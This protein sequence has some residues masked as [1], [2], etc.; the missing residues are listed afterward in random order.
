MNIQAE[1]QT[2]KSPTRGPHNPALLI[3]SQADISPKTR[4][5]ISLTPAPTLKKYSLLNPIK[6][7]LIFND[8]N[9]QG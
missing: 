7:V 5:W 6:V 2:G 4:E 1:P 3:S 8:L 9:N